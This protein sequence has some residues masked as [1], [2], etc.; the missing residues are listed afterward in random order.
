MD[1]NEGVVM[2]G[3][4]GDGFEILKRFASDDDERTGEMGG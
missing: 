2:I 1:E 3:G 4:A